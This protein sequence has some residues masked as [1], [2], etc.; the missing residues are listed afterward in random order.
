MIDNNNDDITFNSVERRRVLFAP[1][2]RLLVI[3]FTRLVKLPTVV[4][5]S[6]VVKLPKVL[7]LLK[8]VQSENLRLL[9]TTHPELKPMSGE[10]WLRKTSRGK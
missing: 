3:H 1:N 5:L 2:S 6:K 8:V 9:I 7:K 4:K 10:K